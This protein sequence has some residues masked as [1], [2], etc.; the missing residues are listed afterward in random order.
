MYC[1]DLPRTAYQEVEQT[2]A[3]GS[4]FKQWVPY[5]QVNVWRIGDQ[6]PADASCK[7]FAM[8]FHEGIR[9]VIAW[10]VRDSSTT[11]EGAPIAM[12][13]FREVVFNP[14]IIHGPV[15]GKALYLDMCNA[16]YDEDDDVAAMAEKLRQIGHAEEDA[17]LV[18]LGDA[19]AKIAEE[20]DDEGG[21]D[22]QTNGAGAGKNARA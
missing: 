7:I 9:A 3:Q 2:D 21:G 8:S 15:T 6:S 18:K 20:E 4:T 11:D 13:Y 22:G 14:H 10:S 16:M 19:L 17:R 12:E 5:D 1:S